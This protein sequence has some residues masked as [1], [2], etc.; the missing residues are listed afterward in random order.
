MHGPLIKEETFQHSSRIQ[1]APLLVSNEKGD[2]ILA[3]W[4]EVINGRQSNVFARI[5]KATAH[6]CTSCNAPKVCKKQNMCVL[7]FKGKEFVFIYVIV[8]KENHCKNIRSSSE[9]RKI[10]F[11]TLF[12]RPKS[13]LCKKWPVQS[14]LP[15]IRHWCNVFL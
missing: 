11:L 9:E 3:L 2:H 10:P 1:R 8:S 4:Q 14:Y 6:D 7:P 15:E 5:L 13:L 12:R